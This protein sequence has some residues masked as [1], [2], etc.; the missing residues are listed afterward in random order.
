MGPTLMMVGVRAFVVAKLLCGSGIEL[1]SFYSF[2]SFGAKSRFYCI[3]RGK[4]FEVLLVP[5]LAMGF[6]ERHVRL[7]A[8][9]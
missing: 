3:P 2:Y 8:I 7:L 5:F 9:A 6:W 1:N 4:G